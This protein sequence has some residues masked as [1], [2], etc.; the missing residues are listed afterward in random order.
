MHLHE[1]QA[2]ALFRRYHIPVGQG[3]A[4]TTPAQAK[5]AWRELGQRS[6]TVKVQVHAGGR[7]KAGGI[8][9]TTA[10][11]EVEAFAR[12]WL[13]Q[14]LVTPQTGPMGRPVKQL[15]V[16]ASTA[17]RCEHYLA[18]TVDRSQ[19][20]PVFVASAQGGIA[21]EEL[22]SSDSRALLTR[23]HPLDQPLTS[24]CTRPLTAHLQLPQALVPSA[25]HIMAGMWRLFH[26]AEASLIEINPLA[27]TRDGQ[28]VA[29]D[30]KVALDDNALFRHPELA[31]WRDPQ[32]DPPLEVE[33]QQRGISY[34]GLD[35]NIGCLVN[36]AGLAMAT[37][38]ILL[39]HGGRPANFLDVGGGANVEQ[40]TRAFQLLLQDQR[41]K[42]VLVN[43]FGGIMQCD[44]VARGLLDA[45]QGVQVRVPLVVRLEGT[46]VEEGRQLLRSQGARLPL[47]TAP[48][49]DEAARLAVQLADHA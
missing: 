40:V 17:I 39:L 22:A 37:N 43:I 49:F 28:L 41:V 29:V 10:G 7:G 25:E 8:L 36:G 46:R 47:T 1:Y 33:A 21:I 12:R 27:E 35:G 13:G 26:E 31:A 32:Q 14:R 18:L 20:T 5:A 6:V 24:D 48:S 3:R 2:K 23:S 45:T 11:N 42:A 16:E 15:L 38:D 9:L 30:A 44:V 34:V 4:V 19:A